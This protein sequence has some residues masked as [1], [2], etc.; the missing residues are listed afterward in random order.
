MSQI[1]DI[2]GMFEK[3]WRLF[4]ENLNFSVGVGVIY[5]VVSVFLGVASELVKY[6]TGID[7]EALMDNFSIEGLIDFLP[8]FL[9]IT[10]VS[11][12]VSVILKLGVIKVFLNLVD[13]GKP[14]FNDL[15]NTAHYLPQYFGAVLLMAVPVLVGFV[16]F[17]VPGFYLYIRWQFFSILIIDKNLGPIE[18]L[19]ESWRLTAGRTLDMFLLFV[20]LVTLTLAGSLALGVGLIFTLPLSMILLANVYRILKPLSVE[21]V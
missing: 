12:V 6:I 4:K 19:K 11:I 9:G 13:G 3:S 16:L 17:I 10:L 20:L 7:E 2:G 1:I 8:I 15:W 5:L 18:A 21:V 14:T